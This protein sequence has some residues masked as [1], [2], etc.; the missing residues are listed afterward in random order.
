M[1]AADIA[2]VRNYLGKGFPQMRISYDASNNPEYIGIAPRGV[3]SSDAAWSIEKLT[4]T[5]GLVTL[6]QT[7]PD[8]SIWD[9][10]TSLTY[11]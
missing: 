10:R 6:S 9:N 8:H 1:N 7:S 4:Y 3:A 11:A 2:I 5:G